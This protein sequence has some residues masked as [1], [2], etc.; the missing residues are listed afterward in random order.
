[1]SLEPS[2]SATAGFERALKK[3]RASQKYVLRLYVT[4][5]SPRSIAAIDNVRRICELHLQGRYELEIIDIYQQPVLA[6]GEQIIAAPTLLKKLPLP[7]RRFIGD[8]SQTDK[9]LLGLDLRLK[10]EEEDQ[11]SAELPGGSS[12]KA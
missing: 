8:M 7:L 5:M 12:A 9:I 6:K 10:K 4:G 1:M 3:K 11:S 2:E